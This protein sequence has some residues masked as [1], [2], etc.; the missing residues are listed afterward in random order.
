MADTNKR[1]KE[2]TAEYVATLVYLDEPQVV[3]LNHGNDA[4][5]IGVAIEKDGFEYPFLGAEVSFT[6]WERYR[7]EFV[8]LRYLFLLP[9]WRK[10]YIFDLAKLDANK[11]IPIK[12][13]EKQDYT[14]KAFLP[15]H[16]FF[17]R[18]HTEPDEYAIAAALATQKY[19]IDG[20]WEPID[21]SAFFGRVND[22]YSFFLGIQKF[23]SANTTA[24]QKR[25]LVEAFTEHPMRGGSSYVNFYGDLKGLLGFDERLAM[26]SIVKQS[27]GFVDLEGK[28]EILDK[29]TGAFENYG[30][31][32]EELKKRYDHLHSYMSK[33]KLLKMEP[34]KF[35]KTSPVAK[36]IK[37]HGQIFAGYLGIEYDTIDR[38]TGHNALAT[39]KILL[40]HWR[41]LDRYHLFFA[42]GRVQFSKEGEE[43]VASSPSINEKPNA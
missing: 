15:S 5:I 41:R 40:S 11:K 16:G 3:L 18:D 22:L 39:V 8:D 30:N 9:R 1:W 6:Q 17:A 23:I 29:I 19:L 34:E 26:G 36:Y 24:I 2:P 38:L 13:A 4:K 37:E 14:N 33:A 42:E 21:L 32:F 31:N 27:P 25:A 35:D 12:Q 20:A 43:P 7:R 10:W 28:S